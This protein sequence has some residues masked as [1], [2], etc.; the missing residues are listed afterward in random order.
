MMYLTTFSCIALCVGIVYLYL[1]WKVTYWKRVGLEYLEPHLIFGNIKD[2]VQQR[3]S[4]GDQLR[5]IYNQ[6]KAQGLKHGGIYFFFVPIYIPVDLDVI[7]NIF[8]RDFEYFVNHGVYK[9]EEFDPLSGHL[10]ALEDDKWKKLRAKLSPTFTTGKIKMMFQTLCSTSK[11]LYGVLEDH[12]RFNDVLDI[13]DLLARFTTDVI[14]SVAFGLECNSLKN[15]NEEFRH[16]G[17]KLF[18]L[19]PI[20]RFKDTLMF[21]FILPLK[22]INFFNL[23]I[24]PK[25]VNTF[26]L[27]VVQKT[28]DYREKNK[29]SRKDF[30]HLL[31]QLKNR[32]KVADDQFIFKQEGEKDGTDFITFNELAAQCLLFFVAGFETSSTTMSFALL[33]LARNKDIQNKLRDE[34]KRVLNKHNNELTYDAIMEMKYLEQVIYESLRKHPPTPNLIRKCTK[35]YIVPG[36]G[37][38]I[39]KG[40]QVLIPILA[41][42]NDPEVYPDP[43]KFD[44]DRFTD[45]NKAKRH[46]AAFLAFGDGPRYCLGA[47]LGLMQTKVGLITFIN[48][49]QVDVHPKTKLPVKYITQRFIMAMEGGVWLSI[50]KL[51]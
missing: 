49:F 15:P 1:K 38:T 32:G 23:K 30:M 22:V 10:F 20:E 51:K 39:K 46:P 13:R 24:F 40:V 3:I 33:E 25:D 27:N 47:R 50:S 8:V 26:F 41:I 19:T 5:N 42:Q 14:A 29:I 45:E 21:M 11:E 7:K 28:I 9:N 36:T 31:L 18:D 6:F 35:D 43:E 17:R 2:M 34:I 37:V 16:K 12:A 44:P 4:I 48:N